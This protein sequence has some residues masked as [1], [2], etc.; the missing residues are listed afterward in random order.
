MFATKN[1]AQLQGS[2]GLNGYDVQAAYSPINKV[3]IMANTS[4][5]ENSG[6]YWSQFIEGGAGYYQTFDA[7]G[8]FECYGGFGNGHTK[9]YDNVVAGN[10][11]ANYN[12][13][14]IQPGI[15]LKQD[16]FES[17]FCTRVSYVDIYDLRSDD[18]NLKPMGAFFVEPVLT[19]KFDYKYVKAFM[20]FGLS[21]NSVK[22]ISIYSV[23]VI[24]NFGLNLSFSQL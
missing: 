20:Q 24:L 7:N 9:L 19:G 23:P 1:D 18:P 13:F 12:R 10:T 14:F 22:V 4:V 2:I 6:S 21:L 3:G 15:G 11:D 17:S 5:S 16:F 8:R